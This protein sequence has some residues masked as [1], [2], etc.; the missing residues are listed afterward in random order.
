[1]NILYAPWREAYVTNSKKSDNDSCSGCVFCQIL[2]AKDSADHHF[3]LKVTSQAFVVLNLYPYNAGHLLIVPREHV[4]TLEDLTPA[5]RAH[6][7]ELMTTS[8]VILKNKIQAQGINA[9]L[10]LGS[11][12]GAGIPAHLHLHVIPR[13]QGDTNFITTIGATKNISV[14]LQKMYET[15]L[16]EFQALSVE[17]I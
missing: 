12:S 10:N 7:M 16:P 15:L 2:L 1:M 9:G 11:A 17:S 8:T 5:T 6:I 3:I 14:D 4:A 13:W